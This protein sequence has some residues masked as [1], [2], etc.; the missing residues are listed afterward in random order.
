MTKRDV[1]RIFIKFWVTNEKCPP[2]L[3]H[4]IQSLGNLSQ[5]FFL[6]KSMNI[7]A[8]IFSLAQKSTISPRENP[9]NIFQ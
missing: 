6:T 3:L 7:E 5:W 9:A 4:V 2:P 8:S 1:E